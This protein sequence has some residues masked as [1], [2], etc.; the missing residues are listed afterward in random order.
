MKAYELFT[1]V[2]SSLVT[3]MLD[4]FRAN[5]RNVYKAAVSSLT[6][7]RKL[8]PVYVERKPRT[9]QYAWIQN[10]LTS[11]QSEVIGEHLLQA[12]LMAGKEEMLAR[13]CDATGIEHDGKGSITGELPTEIEAA[14]VDAAV[15][16]LLKHDDKAVVAVYL[17]V[18]N[19]QRP[20]G[21][22]TLSAKLESD[23][24]LKLG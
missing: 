8:R 3:E 24:R 4:W 5:D 14:K 23:E 12:W 17:Q 1:V 21:W 11:K 15:E 22:P 7:H 20:G 16:E 10:A 19:L 6:S 9:E 13:F 2:P 18:F